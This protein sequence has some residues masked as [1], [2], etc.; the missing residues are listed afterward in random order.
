MRNPA[1]FVLRPMDEIVRSNTGQP[2]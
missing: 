1:W 2:A